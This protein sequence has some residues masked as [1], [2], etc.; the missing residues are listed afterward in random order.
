MQVSGRPLNSRGWRIGRKICE[1]SSRRSR[2]QLKEGDGTLWP[3]GNGQ[4]RLWCRGGERIVL[5]PFELLPPFEQSMRRILDNC[6][7]FGI[8]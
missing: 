7:R 8:E 5:P 2:A 4:A 3:V 6:V 1:S